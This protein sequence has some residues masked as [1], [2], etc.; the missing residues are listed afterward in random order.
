[1]H[2]A[3]SMPRSDG[4]SVC[5]ILHW[6]AVGGED[7]SVA[8]ENDD[9]VGFGDQVVGEGFRSLVGDVRSDLEQDLSRQ[10]VDV[11]PGLTPAES[12]RTV[13]PTA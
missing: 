2:S 10:C 11:A 9:Q 8:A 4:S 7:P 1:M 6:C 3:P 5:L 12:K 13:A